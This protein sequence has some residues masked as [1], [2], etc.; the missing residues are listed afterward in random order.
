MWEPES[1]GKGCERCGGSS[2]ALVTMTSIHQKHKVTLEKMFKGCS[3]FSRVRYEKSAGGEEGEREAGQRT[4]RK[5]EQS[6]VAKADKSSPRSKKKGRRQEREERAAEEAWK[7]GVN[8]PPPPREPR[9]TIAAPPSEEKGLCCFAEEVRECA[10]VLR[11]SPEV[12]PRDSHVGELHS[13]THTCPPLVNLE[14]AA[15][16]RLRAIRIPEQSPFL[17]NPALYAT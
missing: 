5:E 12:V 13:C 11:A 3:P 10:L 6:A 7:W 2:V 15:S 8:L 1:G 14:S 9:R 16:T 4:E 17:S